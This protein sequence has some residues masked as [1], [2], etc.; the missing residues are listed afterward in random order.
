MAAG[1]P[2]ER[3]PALAST[4]AGNAAPPGGAF[5]ALSI[6]TYT[7]FWISGWMWNIARWLGLFTGSYLVYHR[8]GSTLQ[9]QLVGVAYFAP[10]FLG[11]LAGGVI[12]DPFDRLRLVVLQM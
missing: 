7:R 8:G 1:R 12:A 2:I 10:M 3:D 4:G 9:V 6:P 5:S 11:G